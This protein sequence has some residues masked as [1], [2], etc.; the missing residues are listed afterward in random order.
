MQKAV[1]A[2]VLP[3]TA[4]QWM[5]DGDQVTGSR[6]TA[7]VLFLDRKQA[8]VRD[9]DATDASKAGRDGYGAYSIDL[10]VPLNRKADPIQL[11]HQRL[12]RWIGE[13]AWL[14]QHHWELQGVSVLSS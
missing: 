7:T 3:R 11:W 4:F 12:E 2:W 9:G 10:E 5:Y 8:I 6:T 1:F 13:Q 14:K